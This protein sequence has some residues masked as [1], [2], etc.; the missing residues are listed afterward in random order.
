M[1]GFFHYKKRQII[2][3]LW[4]SLFSLQYVCEYNYELD[5]NG[6]VVAGSVSRGCIERNLCFT[7]VR[8]HFYLFNEQH[9]LLILMN[10]SNDVYDLN[11]TLILKTQHSMIDETYLKQHVPF[12]D[13]K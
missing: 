3:G 5:V 13:N 4:R 1:K 7:N 9:C 11:M 8:R 6:D 12:N 2:G 10:H